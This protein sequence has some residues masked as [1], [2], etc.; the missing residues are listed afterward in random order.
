MDD[1]DRNPN[2][3]RHRPEI[4]GPFAVLDREV[5]FAEILAFEPRFAP[6][7]NVP[8][9]QGKPADAASVVMWYHA[10]AFCRWL[11]AEAGYGEHDQ[12]YPDPNSLDPDAYPRETDERAA[13]TWAPYNWPVRLDRPGFR[14]PTEAEWEIACRGG[15]RTAYGHG[16]DRSLLRHYAWYSE[17]GGKHGHQ[18]KTRRPGLRGLFDLHGNVWEWCHDW[19]GRFP[20]TAP[21]GP[22]T[23]SN[24]ILRG[25]SWFS[26]AELC[27]S[28]YRG[29]NR[30]T[31]RNENTGLR[32]A[33]SLMSGD[34]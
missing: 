24:R 17:N 3:T 25:G 10:V 34:E 29:T 32:L 31:F 21:A 6:V 2:E 22:A 13:A 7:L 9:V 5:T 30:P 18:P 15:M 4:S 20:T 11:T 27:R 12:P 23:G 28:S 8:E 16:S 26:A 19:N 1:E 33:L 14:L